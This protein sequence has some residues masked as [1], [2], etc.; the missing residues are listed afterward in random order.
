[1]MPCHATDQRAHLYGGKRAKTG[2]EQRLCVGLVVM[3]QREVFR[4]LTA[5]GN[6]DR[7]TALGG[8]RFTLSGLAQWAARL[9]YPGA[10][11]EMVSLDDGVR[12]FTLPI[13]DRTVLHPDVTLPWPDVVQTPAAPARRTRTRA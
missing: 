8:D 12:K 6:V 2:V 3:V 1:M 5:H 10:T 11:F 9:N 7:Y 13:V 4:F